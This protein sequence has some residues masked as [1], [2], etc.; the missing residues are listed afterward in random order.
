M[1]EQ[2]NKLGYSIFLGLEQNEYLREI[3]DALL[4]NYFLRIFHIETIAPKEMYTEDAL[5]FADLLSKSVQVPLYEMHRSL[6]Q[7]IVTLFESAYPRRQGNRICNG[8]RACKHKQLSW[9]AEQYT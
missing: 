5:T 9:F 7:E 2:N 6:A 4:H 3:Y 8:F 1:T